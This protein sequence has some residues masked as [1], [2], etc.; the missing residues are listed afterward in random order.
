MSDLLDT[1]AEPFWQPSPTTRWSVGFKAGRNV[2]HLARSE[3]DEQRDLLVEVQAISSRQAISQAFVLAHQHLE[4]PYADRAYV[5][6]T[7]KDRPLMFVRLREAEAFRGLVVGLTPRTVWVQ[8]ID[9]V[10]NYYDNPMQLRR[11]GIT[12]REVTA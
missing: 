2:T 8:P 6:P 7:A 4:R 12:V 11:A 3:W 1:Y 9:H 5:V 10:T